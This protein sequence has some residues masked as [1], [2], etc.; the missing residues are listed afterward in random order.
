M[1]TSMRFTGTRYYYVGRAERAS[2]GLRLGADPGCNVS[3]RRGHLHAAALC[4][5]LH[6]VG[7][8][9]F[10]LSPQS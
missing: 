10:L 3:A 2:G 1:Q 4:M 6:Q 5:H 7:S 8:D 9:D